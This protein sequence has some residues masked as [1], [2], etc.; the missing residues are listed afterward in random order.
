MS[1]KYRTSLAYLERGRLAQ[2][3]RY[4]LMTCTL[5]LDPE[6]FHTMDG[7]CLRR[8]KVVALISSIWE[9][10]RAPTTLCALEQEIKVHVQSLA[11]DSHRVRVKSLERLAYES[12]ILQAERREIG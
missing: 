11:K 12:L 4:T 6:P 5:L 9:Y 2:P 1:Y 7:F 3:N 10:L 8:C